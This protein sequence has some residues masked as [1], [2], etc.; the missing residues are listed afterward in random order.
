MTNISV[1]VPIFEEELIVR[2]LCSRLHV[3]LV[4]ITHDYEIIF[5]LDGGKDRSWEIIQELASADPRV[6]CL[7]FSRNFGQHLAISAGL[8]V[9]DGDWVIVMDGDLQDRPEVIP[10]LYAK[11]QEGYDVV[12]VARR[13]RPESW[14]Y[15]V[16][17]QMFHKAFRWLSGIQSSSEN[18]NF[19]IISRKVVINYRQLREQLRY[20]GG[21]VHWL[22]FKQATIPAEHG[23]RFAGQSGYGGWIKRLRLAMQII[24]A[25]S[26]RPLYASV[27][28][29]F[30]M[31]AGSFIA[32]VYFFFRALFHGFDDVPG[33]ASL[34]VVIFFNSGLILL[35]LGVLG[36]YLGKVYNAVKLRPL[37]II[38]RHV[39]LVSTDVG[40]PGKTT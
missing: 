1:V 17:A 9:C 32:G 39:G 40:V 7:E 14:A 29:G 13:N 3:A 18:S 26:E 30:A 28:L 8:D 24:L 34:I 12:F 33:W 10:A 15:Q 20:Y 19:S 2:E 27:A 21:I 36:V 38:S 11:A 4:S 25:Y 16:T 22:G 31:A 23:T 6:K 5:V 37:Y 35:V